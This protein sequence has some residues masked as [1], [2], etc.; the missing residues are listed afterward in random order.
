[1]NKVIHALFTTRCRSITCGEQFLVIREVRFDQKTDDPYD[2]ETFNLSFFLGPNYLV[3]VH[4][5][6]IVGALA[7]G[8]IGAVGGGIVGSNAAASCRCCA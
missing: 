7:G 2:L 4:G 3:T 8:A 5:E 1:M 6:G